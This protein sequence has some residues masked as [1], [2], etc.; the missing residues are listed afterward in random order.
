MRS[1][2]FSLRVALAALLLAC[3]PVPGHAATV[4]EATIR[5]R[6]GDRL[7]V[8]ELATTPEARAQGLMH[9]TTLVPHDGMLFLFPEPGPYRFWMKDTP[10]PLDM[11]FIDAHGRI[12]YIATNT[13]PGSMSP[14]GPAGDSLAVIELDAGRAARDAIAVGDEVR[15]ALPDLL[16]VR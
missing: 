15:Y 8:L 7:L 4:V 2:R 12:H 9:R 6:H 5:T 13:M 14:I 10:L 3:T 16:V 11:L 1:A